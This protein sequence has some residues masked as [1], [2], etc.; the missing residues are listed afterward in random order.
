[1]LYHNIGKAD[2]FLRVLLGLFLLGAGIVWFPSYILTFLMFLVGILSLSTGIVGW[3]PEYSIFGFSTRRTGLNKI[4]KKDIEKAVSSYT[5]KE[6]LANA[7]FKDVRMTKK[8]ASKKATKKSVKK[9]TSK[10]SVKKSSK[11]AVV[12]KTTKKL[13]KTTTKKNK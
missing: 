10:K 7:G 11:K 5:F 3:A 2:R 8:V 13:T 4:T 1:M 12:K 9:V 6:E